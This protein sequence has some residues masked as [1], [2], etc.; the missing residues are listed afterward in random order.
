ML[1]VAVAAQVD[2]ALEGLFAEAARERLVARVFAHVR[3]QVRRLAERL[4]AHDALVRF[5]A[6]VD[7]G[8]FLHV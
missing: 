2:L 5:L 3:D 7:V 1:R 8:V 6:C 4:A